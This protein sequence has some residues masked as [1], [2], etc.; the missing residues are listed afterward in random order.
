MI[1]SSISRRFY[2]YKICWCLCAN[3]VLKIVNRTSFRETSCTGIFKIIVIVNILVLFIITIIYSIFSLV[4]M[5]KA[6]RF[7]ATSTFW[8]Y[9]P[10][11]FDLLCCWKTSWNGTSYACYIIKSWWSTI[12]R[13]CKSTCIIYLRVYIRSMWCT[14]WKWTWSYWTGWVIQVEHP[15]IRNT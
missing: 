10:S 2:F 5:G 14:R 3:S 13:Y 12:W 9:V 1:I 4:N 7:W 6:T 8:A 11:Y 15:S